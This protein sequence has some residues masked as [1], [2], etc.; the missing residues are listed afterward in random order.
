MRLCASYQSSCLVYSEVLRNLNLRGAA[1][2]LSVILQNRQKMNKQLLLI[3]TILFFG[4]VT[5][6]QTKCD[7]KNFYKAIE[8]ESDVKVLTT[9]GE[10]EEA[11]YILVP[12]KLDEGKYKLSVTR[13]SSNLYKVDGQDIY[14]E[15]MYCYEYA[16]ADD[17]ILIVKSNYGYDKGEIIF[18]D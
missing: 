7:V 4:T 2:M 14:I 11:E 9:G 13:K 15:T 12:T 5:Y 6:G 17:V 10:M 16:A 1:K 18:I 3:S 8:A